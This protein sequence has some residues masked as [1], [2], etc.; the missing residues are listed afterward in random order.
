MRHL[1]PLLGQVALVRGTRS[2]GIMGQDAPGKRR[3]DH[4]EHLETENLEFHSKLNY[5]FYI[6]AVTKSRTLGNSGLDSDS[7]VRES[8]RF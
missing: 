1:A 6:L 4:H 5:I 7:K 3:E 8:I 2:P